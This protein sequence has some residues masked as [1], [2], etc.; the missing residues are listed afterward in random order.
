[1]IA[2]INGW[3]LGGALELALACDIRI[4]STE[5]MFGL[6]LVRFGF[7]T[8][9]GGLARLGAICGLGVALDLTLSA[10]PIDVARA[11]ACNLV[12]RSASRTG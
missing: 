3:V 5:A 12:T 8:G 11:L 2:A 4:A 6:P 10:E 9:D 1:M 7:H